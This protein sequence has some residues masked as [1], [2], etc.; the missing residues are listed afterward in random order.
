MS[1]TCSLSQGRWSEPPE[2]HWGDSLVLVHA[3][4]I[5]ESALD[6]PQIPQFPLQ[7]TNFILLLDSY[8][9]IPLPSA[10]GAF[11]TLLCPPHAQSSLRIHSSTAL[12][13][14]HTCLSLTLL[15]P[16]ISLFQAT[17][18]S[19]R[20]R[21]TF[22]GCQSSCTFLL[23]DLGSLL[24]QDG[25]TYTHSARPCVLTLFPVYGS[26]HQARLPFKQMLS[27]VQAGKP[28][29]SFNSSSPFSAQIHSL[30]RYNDSGISLF[31]SFTFVC[32]HPPTH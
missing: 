21:W 29:I 8:L 27:G 12:S 1:P 25:V 14:T 22:P 15:P 7:S 26:P 17:P 24:Y 3:V 23:S 13:P 16:S 31:S 9:P 20:H 30:F 28:R 4:S 5:A 18:S 10:T 2:A 19:T 6:H 32:H 11:K